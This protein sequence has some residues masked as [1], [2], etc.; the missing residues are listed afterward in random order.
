MPSEQAKKD[1]KLNMPPRTVDQKYSQVMAEL[2]WTS[3][4]NPGS[5]RMVVLANLALTMPAELMYS[6]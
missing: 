6:C 1:A 2:Q 4:Q 5:G 3:M